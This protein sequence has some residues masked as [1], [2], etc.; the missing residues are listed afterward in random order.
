MQNIEALYGDLM[1]VL[2]RRRH[3]KN[4]DKI[5]DLNLRKILNKSLDFRELLDSLKR[6][7]YLHKPVNHL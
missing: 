2:R 6:H 3:E 7:V 4:L 5:T 1:Q